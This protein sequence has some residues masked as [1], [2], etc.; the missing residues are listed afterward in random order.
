MKLFKLFK[1]TVKINGFTVQEGFVALLDE[2]ENP[3]A[4]TSGWENNGEYF[5]YRQRPTGWVGE[6]ESEPAFPVAEVG[7]LIAEYRRS[8]DIQKALEFAK[9]KK[10]KVSEEKLTFTEVVAGD[11]SNNGGEYGF[12]TNY[13][14]ISEH[15]G[16]YEVYSCSSCDFDSCGTGYEGIRALTM[17][18]YRRLRRASDKV[19]AAGS[20]Y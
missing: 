18:E 11:K 7:E 6:W 3:V 8:E 10:L 15:P 12:W 16:L 1:E 19:E 4:I 2:K 13:Y 14:P 17:S 5:V 20:L 9:G